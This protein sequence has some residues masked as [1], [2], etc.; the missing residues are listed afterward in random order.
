MFLKVTEIPTPEKVSCSQLADAQA[1]KFPFIALPSTIS[2]A[3]R[4]TKKWW[5]FRFPPPTSSLTAPRTSTVQLLPAVRLASETPSVRR[6]RRTR[7]AVGPMAEVLPL[8]QPAGRHKEG[9]HR[10]AVAPRTHR[11]AAPRR[12]AGCGDGAGAPPP[13]PA[14]AAALGG[15]SE[16]GGS[17][18]STYLRGERSG[19]AAPASRASG[20]RRPVSSGSPRLS[21]LGREGARASEQR[22]LVGGSG[23]AGPGRGGGDDDGGGGGGRRDRRCRDTAGAGRRA[24]L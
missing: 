16:R 5:G 19:R 3:C 21:R 22:R 10:A 4:D 23:A 18:F 8:D 24:R 2:A 1:K 12:R 15:D 9:G 13:P 17:R 14:A 6:R 20:D 7:R 11:P